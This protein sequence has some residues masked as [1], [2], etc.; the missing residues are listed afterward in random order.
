MDFALSEEQQMLQTSAHRFFAERHPL[1]RAR[2]ALPWSD[3]SQRKLWQDMAD[4][5]WFG[6]LVSEEQGGLGLGMCEAFLVAEAAGRQLVNLPYAASAVLLPRL[7]GGQASEPDV[8][9]GLVGKVMSGKAAVN[10]SFEGTVYVDYEQQC[11][12]QLRLNGV[13]DARRAA[14]VAALEISSMSP[15]T[16]HAAMTGLDPTLRLAG[17]TMVANGPPMPLAMAADDLAHAI[18]AYRVARIGEIL[19][20]AAACLDLSC[21]YAR[22]REQFGQRIGA[23]QAVKHHLSNAWMALDNAR[24]AS[25]YAAAAL[26]SNR[27]DWRF[28]CAA[29]EMTA[30]EG[31]LHV[32]RNAIQVHGGLGF[33]WEHDA[34]LY[35]KRIHHVSALLGGYDAA[36][37]M[38]ER[39]C[40]AEPV[41]SREPALP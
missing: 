34:H 40:D 3:A 17:N 10:I 27:P 32:A 11:S 6:L 29:A 2:L 37:E 19:G 4:M 18:A 21:D 41:G 12:H 25:L 36:C 39:A 1:Q 35:L 26:D 23:Y 5:G 7:S 30:I 33:S 13:A 38:L 22:T 15:G 31:G 20:A 16:E 8:L 28:A 14:S 9:G 24:L